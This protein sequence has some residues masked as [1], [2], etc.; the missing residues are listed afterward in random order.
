MHSIA[1]DR[2]W[3]HFFGTLKVSS[4][5]V[6]LGLLRYSNV[7]ANLVWRGYWVPTM[8]H[9]TLHPRRRLP[10]FVCAHAVFHHLPAMWTSGQLQ[11]TN[12]SYLSSV[13][14]PTTSTSQQPHMCGRLTDPGTPG[15]WSLTPREKSGG[16]LW[17]AQGPGGGFPSDD[18]L[19]SCPNRPQLRVLLVK[20]KLL[21]WIQ[22]GAEKPKLVN[23]CQGS[24]NQCANFQLKRSEVRLRVAQV[25]AGGCII[26]WH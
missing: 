18:N 16:Q 24:S 14:L 8:P 13:I 1:L 2:Q 19:C 11:V 22:K 6:T 10:W 15:F 21:T 7:A 23:V 9:L 4:S 12:R 20:H 3:L 5:V 17:W 25:L 26:R